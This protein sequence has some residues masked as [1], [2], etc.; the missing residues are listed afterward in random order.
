MNKILRKMKM[1]VMTG[2]GRLTG[3][4]Q[5]TKNWFQKSDVCILLRKK[6]LKALKSNSHLENTHL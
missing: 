3:F 2:N 5:V 4:L 6:N 1:N